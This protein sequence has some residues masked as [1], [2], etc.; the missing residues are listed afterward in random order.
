MRVLLWISVFIGV[1]TCVQADPLF[2][3]HP[4]GD[5][6]YIAPAGEPVDVLVL[7]HGT[8]PSDT[9][10]HEYALALANRW[11]DFA[12]QT[13]MLLIIPVFDDARFGNRSGGY[14]GYRGLFGRHIG[15]DEFVLLAVREQQEQ[16]GMPHSPFFLYG[17]SAGAQFAVRFTIQHPYAVKS[18]IAAGA[19]RYSYP[20][21]DARWP[22]GGGL[23][24]RDIEWSD[25]TV[26]SVVQHASL[27]QYAEAVGKFHVLVGADD[28]ERQPRRPGHEGRTRP[29]LAVTWVGAM[30]RNAVLHDGPNSALASFEILPNV[31]HV[32]HILEEEARAYIA[33]AL[34]D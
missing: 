15:A 25:G 4:E 30:N 19:G 34:D 10:A 24:G 23:L 28:L 12:Q 32:S 22:Y 29:E 21:L 5:Y 26:Q 1:C 7:A 31:G 6:F 16:A 20:T 18:T 3:E 8:R 9:F 14:G 11:S 17:H 13:G 33:R 27:A 2:V